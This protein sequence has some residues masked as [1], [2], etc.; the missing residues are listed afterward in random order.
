MIDVM[1]VSVG[2]QKRGC[3]YLWDSGSVSERG[4]LA[5]AQRMRFLPGLHAKGKERDDTV[6]GSPA[7]GPPWL[8]TS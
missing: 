3:V 8:A 2:A 1:G 4:H 7:A 6:A 5:G